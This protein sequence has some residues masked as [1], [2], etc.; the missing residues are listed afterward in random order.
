MTA[1][2]PLSGTLSTL[3]LAQR[4]AGHFG[5]FLQGR[6]GA[7][8]PVVVVSA[9]CPVLSVVAQAASA[10][11]AAS[12]EGLPPGAEALLAALNLAPPPF[13]VVLQCDMPAG[14]GAGS[15]TASL[16]A[17]A[18]LAGW[19]GAPEALARAC[20]LAE[21]ASDPLMFPHPE[22]LLFASRQGRVVADLPAMPA[23]TVVGGFCGQDRPT[24]PQ[25]TDFP[26]IT[27][28][29]TDWRAAAGDLPRLAALVTE[30]ARRTLVLRGPAGDPTDGLARAEGALGWL[31]AHTGS[32]RG[33]IFAPGKVP[34]GLKGRLTAAG[35]RQVVR[36]GVGG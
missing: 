10:D 15:S 4:V 17:L 13:G 34:T 2:P 1:L 14:G 18:R 29:V 35:F 23:L 31:I 16:V 12:T 22:R 6:L 19:Q 24:D 32:A 21:G 30:S 33:L 9:P 11:S 20:L 26:D 36:F 7:G 8:G 25:D 28:L 27:D 3:P 5:E